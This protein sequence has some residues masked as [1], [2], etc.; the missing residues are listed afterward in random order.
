MILNAED[1]GYYYIP[2]LH[3]GDIKYKY[4][5]PDFINIDTKHNIILFVKDDKQYS[6]IKP[7]EYFNLYFNESCVNFQQNI[8]LDGHILLKYVVFGNVFIGVTNN[9][10]AHVCT[11]KNIGS[12]GNGINLNYRF[13]PLLAPV[14]K[15]SKIIY[16]NCMY[17][18]TDGIL[19]IWNNIC[20]ENGINIFRN[21]PVKYDFG[22]PE[23]IPIVTDINIYKISKNYKFTLAF[24]ED[25][26]YNL[27][28]KDN[29][30]YKVGK[31]KII[32]TDKY[33]KSNKK[34]TLYILCEDGKLYKYYHEMDKILLY[35]TDVYQIC[36]IRIRI[37]I[38][39]NN[40]KLSYSSNVIAK[41][42][43][44]Y[45]EKINFIGEVIEQHCYHNYNL[46]FDGKV[47]YLLFKDSVYEINEELYYVSNYYIFTNCNRY[48]IDE[49]GIKNVTP[50]DMQLART[51]YTRKKVFVKSA[52]K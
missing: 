52:R 25:G 47:A 37:M 6:I 11:E 15:N 30:L 38:I 12:W 16:N 31:I 1:G 44:E 26:F 2:D 27:C 35:E 39:H 45:I 34:C 41:K 42:Y 18:L 20:I 43:K 19:Y 7:V 49:N 48:S 50:H 22:D 40:G 29:K 17:L 4:I 14:N 36:D 8:Y 5:N 51:K 24:T 9:E 10:E 23:N 33:T 21:I 13:T 46:I 3:K 32:L 28:M